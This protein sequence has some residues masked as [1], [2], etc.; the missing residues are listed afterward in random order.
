MPYSGMCMYICIYVCFLPTSF[1]ELLDEEEEEEGKPS[2]LVMVPLAD[3][4]NHV[5]NHNANLEFSPEH[6]QMVAT[7]TIP[8]GQEVFNTYGKLSNWQLLHMYGFAEPYPGNTNDAADIPM[9][10]LLQAALEGAKTEE[11]RKLTLEQ[12]A[13]L[14]GL[15]M[16]GEEG[17]FVIG[18]EDVLTEEE[19]YVSLKVGEWPRRIF[20]H[21]TQCGAGAS[22]LTKAALPALAPPWKRL[23]SNAALL[24]L[25]AYGS[26]LKAE[27]E[28]LQQAQAYAQ[29]S[30]RERHA[31]QV[32]YGKK[33][34][35]HQL[36][37]LLSG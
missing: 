18:W 25:E 32:R 11:E 33:K 15:E 27:E 16:V 3:L 13:Y 9:L 30:P 19:L 29:L 26:D 24:T 17:A 10:T 5:A 34:I 31:L 8:K 12:W 2:P 35:L 1:Q 22:R 36:L 37:Q 28:V 23:L 4:L 6:L 7:R 21:G 14:C 20:W